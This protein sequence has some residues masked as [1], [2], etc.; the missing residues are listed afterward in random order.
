VGK[1]K[2]RMDRKAKEREKLLNV[3]FASVTGNPTDGWEVTADVGVC[4]AERKDGKKYTLTVDEMVL[5]NDRMAKHVES[6]KQYNEKK[7]KEL[8]EKL[9]KEKE[10][11][12]KAKAADE[13][14]KKAHESDN[15]DAVAYVDGTAVVVPEGLNSIV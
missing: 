11:Q 4:T 14:Y 8:Q 9:A 5:L 13:A 6:M 10:E 12:E 2:I 7:E 3:V 15:V 1:T